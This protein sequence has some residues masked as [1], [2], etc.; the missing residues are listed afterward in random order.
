MGR[1][2]R[3]PC[4]FE[5][6]KERRKKKHCIG[7]GSDWS[8]DLRVFQSAYGEFSS[9]S[10]PSEKSCVGQEGADLVTLH[11]VLLEKAREQPR[12]CIMAL[13]QNWWRIQGPV[14]GLTV[15]SAPHG[16]RWEKRFHDRHME[17]RF[18]TASYLEGKE[19]VCTL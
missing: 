7:R 1:P 2:V 19:E 6:V 12:G 3:P 11:V 14:T 18:L 4:R 17:L 15:S 13:A 9:K 16:R 8:T 10:C 5:D